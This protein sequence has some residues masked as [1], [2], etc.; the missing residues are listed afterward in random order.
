MLHKIRL[1]QKRS[2]LA[3]R[4]TMPGRNAPYGYP[5]MVTVLAVLA[6]LAISQAR[7]DLPM[8]PAIPGLPEPGGHG[9]ICPSGPG[10]GDGAH[11]LPDTALTGPEVSGIKAPG[12][13][14]APATMGPEVPALALLNLAALAIIAYLGIKRR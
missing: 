11:G 8:P 5:V 4:V 6:L 14:P 3:K 12:F 13:S 9:D 7:A 10:P 2:D 1:L